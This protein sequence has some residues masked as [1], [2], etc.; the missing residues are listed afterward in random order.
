L[1]QAVF[2]LTP[3]VKVKVS[4]NYSNFWPH[5]TASQPVT[6]V[7][8]D[9]ATPEVLEKFGY[10]GFIVFFCLRFVTTKWPH[11]IKY[12]YVELQTN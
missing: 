4:L 1:K 8:L 2:L 12:E 5:D 7:P 10:A 6:P 11:F 3:Q 9:E